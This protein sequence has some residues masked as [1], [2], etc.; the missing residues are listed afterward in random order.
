MFSFS[1][2]SN[3]N[4]IPV[5]DTQADSSYRGEKGTYYHVT[6]TVWVTQNGKSVTQTRTV[7]K[8]S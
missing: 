7:R 5:I 1:T 6:Q 3:L 8:T 2:N 4:C